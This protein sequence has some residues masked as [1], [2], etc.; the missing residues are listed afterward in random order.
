MTRA[1]TE[2]ARGHRKQ[3]CSRCPRRH[4]EGQ[5]LGPGLNEL[6]PTLQA[7]RGTSSPQTSAGMSMHE[8]EESIPAINSSSP[9]RMG[10]RE[11]STNVPACRGA[12]AYAARAA[13]TERTVPHLWLPIPQQ[14]GLGAA[15]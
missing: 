9:V 5:S 2:T 1:A 12:T 4:V 11:Y 13:A 6:F 15:V 14:H 10:S 3:I 8:A 7:E